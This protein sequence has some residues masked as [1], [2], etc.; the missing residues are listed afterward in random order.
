MKLNCDLGESYGSWKMGQDEQI[1][2]SVHQVNIACGFHA[3]DPLTMRKTV[4]LAKLNKVQIG[5]HPSYPDITGFGRRSMNCSKDEIISLLHYQIAALDGLCRTAGVQLDY[6]KPHGALYNDM[7]RDDEIRLTVLEAISEYSTSLKLMQLATIDAANHQEQAA[8]FGVDLILEGFADRRYTGSGRLQA[9]S[10]T[11]SVLSHEEALQ[12]AKQMLE[13]QQVY[14]C[15]DSLLPLKIDSLCVHGD[16]A[17]ALESARSI[18]QL[19]D[20]HADSDLAAA[21]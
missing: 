14:T 16:N 17:A 12:Q 2:P 21:K 15:D 11:G 5:A 18:R 8:E 3:G 9:R 10:E 1:M 13:L 20:K 6:V 7:M 19:L 4:A